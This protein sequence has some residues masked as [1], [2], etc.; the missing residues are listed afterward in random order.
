MLIVPDLDN[1]TVEAKFFSSSKGEQL[2]E[3]IIDAIVTNSAWGIMSKKKNYLE[4]LYHFDISLEDWKIVRK[5]KKGKPHEKY[6]AGVISSKSSA[7]SKIR[8]SLDEKIDGTILSVLCL[9]SMY[10]KM[11]QIKEY[12]EQKFS[13]F[14]IKSAILECQEFVL[15]I[16]HGSLGCK[17]IED[18]HPKKLV[19]TKSYEFL[20]NT[21][22]ERELTKRILSSLPDAKKE[23]YICGW[24][25]QT[26]IP[27]VKT[28]KNRGVII[29]V[30]T[31]TPSEETAGRGYKDKATAMGQLT[32]VLNKEDIRLVPTCHGRFII[33]DDDNIFVGSMDM[34]SE[35]FDQREECA[36]WSDDPSLVIRAKV[37]FEEL[38]KSGK[39]PSR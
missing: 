20:K 30:I 7:P 13:I 32:D 26:I 18:P 5:A 35:S 34:D 24:I 17:I 15:A 33:I 10:T 21:K 14:E 22:E 37:C 9:P 1:I 31:K 28:L 4:L 38:F 16:F 6:F 25:G 3:S 19:E 29:K 12:E 2:R 39:S 11:T 27:V 23:V 8:I 36:I